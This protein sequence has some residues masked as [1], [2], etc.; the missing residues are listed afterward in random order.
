[1]YAPD[2]QGVQVPV[3]DGN[4]VQVRENGGSIYGVVGDSQGYLYAAGLWESR[5]LMRFNANTDEWDAYYTG[6]NCAIYGIAVDARNRI[7]MGCSDAGWGPYHNSIGGGV[8]VFDPATNKVTRF[9]VPNVAGNPL[10]AWGSTLPV[11]MACATNSACD[12]R[13][14]VSAL[15]V[16]PATGH[17]WATA[18]DNG[19]MFRLSLDE[20]DWSNSQWT[21]IPVLRDRNTNEF[22]EDLFLRNNN[23]VVI[24]RD[25][26]GIGFDP[27]GYV[28]HLGMATMMVFRV[29]PITLAREDIVGLGTGG[30]YTYS[31]FTGSTAFSFTAP[32]GFWRYFYDT[33]FPNAQLDGIR[34]E[35][36]VPAE[37]GIGIR[38][39]ALDTN[40]NPLSSWLPAD[41]YFDYPVGAANYFVDLA[42]G[43]GPLT[44]AT[45]EVEV[46]MTSTDPNLR[47]FLYELDLEWQRP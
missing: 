42:A 3:L 36:H 16:E 20:T 41:G 4:G 14:R 8:A 26:R 19:Y 17:I 12:N 10:P 18:R 6:F 7:W 43:G 5:G 22:L 38:V 13:F 30:H 31:D 32:R 9:Y 29:D 25:M 23:N 28:W 44:G 2:A 45:F 33:G 37:T 27:A 24:S 34:V 39:R 21:F 46:R 1:L 15:A 47:P 35:A 40:N 11:Q